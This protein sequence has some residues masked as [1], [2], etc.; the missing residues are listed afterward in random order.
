MSHMPTPE[1]ESKSYKRSEFCH[2]EIVRKYTI[3]RHSDY[4]GSLSGHCRFG[5]PLKANPVMHFTEDDQL[6][7]WR[8]NDARPAPQKTYDS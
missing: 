6:D 3:H 1:E 7:L 2:T 8:S 4:C 5:F